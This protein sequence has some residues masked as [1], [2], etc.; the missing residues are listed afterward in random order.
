M[1]KSLPHMIFSFY[2]SH[3]IFLIQNQ[4]KSHTKEINFFDFLFDFLQK[5]LVKLLSNWPKKCIDKTV[6]GPFTYLT[7]K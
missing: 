4:G 7:K 2:L 1:I 5:L 6:F 3:F